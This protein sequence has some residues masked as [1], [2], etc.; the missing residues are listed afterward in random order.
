MDAPA[1]I[2][3]SNEF[4]RISENKSVPDYGADY[5]GS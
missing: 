2:Y 3:F 4:S 1:G 5:G